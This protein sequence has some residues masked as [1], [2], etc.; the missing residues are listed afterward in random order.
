MST[1]NLSDFI[2]KISDRIGNYTKPESLTQWCKQIMSESWA[3]NLSYAEHMRSRVAQ[4]LKRV[5]T[6]DGFSLM[7][8]LQ[9][10][11]IF[12]SPVSDEFVQILRDAKFKIDQDKKKKICWFSTEDDSVVRFSDHHSSVKYFQ[13][14]LNL[15]GSLWKNVYNKKMAQEKEQEDVENDIPSPAVRKIKEEPIENVPIEP[16]QEEKGAKVKE[17]PIGNITMKQE[18]EQEV[19]EFMVIDRDVRHTAFNGRIN[20]DELDEQEF[21]HPGFPQNTKLET[22]IRPQKRRQSLTKV[23]A[24]RAKTE[25]I[26][27]PA[28]SSESIATSSIKKIVKVETAEKTPARSSNNSVQLTNPETDMSVIPKDEKSIGTFSTSSNI[29]STAEATPKV[30]SAISNTEANTSPG[31][32]ATSSKQKLVKVEKS[33]TSRESSSI[34]S[35]SISPPDASSSVETTLYA[36]A[37]PPSPEATSTKTPPV[38]AKI[39][40]IALVTQIETIASYNELKSLEKK[41][42]R[43]I[44]KMSEIGDKNISVKKFNLLIGSMIVSLEENRIPNNRTSISFM[45]LLKQ[46][47]LFLIKPLGPQIVHEAME[48]VAEKTEEFKNSTDGVPPTLLSDCLT[49]LLI[50]TGFYNQLN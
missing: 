22:P 48:T 25:E 12:S 6:L 7:E 32:I 37:Q 18:P 36:S 16:K 43:A 26:A 24:K 30:T 31:S 49:N 20:Y 14:V 29:S 9:L 33:K 23:S 46:L 28:T 40:V 19:D 21:V 8:K 45:V 11:F 50:S 3:D 35:N 34:T 5:E 4:K 47:H 38:E 1:I 15:N 27:S 10:V 41:A 39:S 17:E 2:R 13:G 42:S 44:E